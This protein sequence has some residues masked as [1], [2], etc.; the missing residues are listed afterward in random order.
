VPDQ[1]GKLYALNAAG[2]SPS[3]FP[4]TLSSGSQCVP[5]ILNL[6]DDGDLEILVGTMGGLDVIDYKLN[7]GCNVCWNTFRGN[8]RRT[9]FY[10]DGFYGVSVSD[11]LA[12]A[13]P[14][15]FALHPAHP[16]PFNP[17]TV[18]SYQLPVASQVALRV[19]DTAG[20]LVQ[21][22]VNGR[23]DAGSHEVMFDASHLP[24]G[25]YFYRLEAGTFRAAQ[26]LVLLK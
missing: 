11:P 6:D 16:N 23:R 26:K 8:L 18:L 24:S 9:G 19:Y 2:D 15:S 10:G 3:N 14:S 4:F 22:L 17:R 5:T 12:G 13:L 1:T 21:T 20:R 7:G 25:I